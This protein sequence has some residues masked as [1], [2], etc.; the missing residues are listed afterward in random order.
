MDDQSKNDSR[1]RAMETLRAHHE[2][3]EVLRA[4]AARHFDAAT[5]GRIFPR[6]PGL[7]VTIPAPPDGA[8]VIT[9]SVRKDGYRGAR[10]VTVGPD[11]QWLNLERRVLSANG[12][13][14]K[15]IH[16]LTVAVNPGEAPRI[17][18]WHPATVEAEAERLCA[19]AEQFVADPAGT[20]A[21]SGTHCGFCGRALTDPESRRRG[22][23]PECF[24]RWGDFMNYLTVEP[25]QLVAVD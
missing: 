5:R 14:Y 13:S 3:I 9:P 23:G 16:R 21:A 17:T 7:K 6:S 25:G 10:Q 22:I 20:I 4:A 11:R 19:T 1:A 12:K 2:A 15:P 24:G 8:M 18:S